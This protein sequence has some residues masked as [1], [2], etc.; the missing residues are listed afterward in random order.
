MPSDAELLKFRDG[1]VRLDIAEV[2][3]L[4]AAAAG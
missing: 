3:E 4:L 2:N 1:L